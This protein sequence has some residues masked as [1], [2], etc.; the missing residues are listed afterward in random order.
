MRT[1][2]K[3]CVNSLRGLRAT[4]A[5]VPKTTYYDTVYA[6]GKVRIT[7]I[8]KTIKELDGQKVCVL[9][10]EGACDTVFTLCQNKDGSCKYAQFESSDHRCCPTCDMSTV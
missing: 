10:K 2:D 5:G 1:T 4:V 9:V 3:T 8:D 6:T 7:S